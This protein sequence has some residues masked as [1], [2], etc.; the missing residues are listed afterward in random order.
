ME[1]VDIYDAQGPPP[2]AR[3]R[4]GKLPWPRGSTCWLWACGL[5]TGRVTS[6]SPSAA[7]RSAGPPASGRTPPATPRPG[8]TAPAA[9]AREIRR[10]LAWRLPRSSWS[11]WAAAQPP[12]TISARTTAC[13]C[14]SGRSALTFQP[15]ETCA[16]KWVTPEELDKMAQSGELSPSVLS[17]LEGSYR[18]AFL[19]FIGR[20][21]ST[22]LRKG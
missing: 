12:A 22:L 20:Q 15:G 2:P 21:G 10:R 19:Q 16:A 13:A 1:L 9:M 4:I 6:S 7:R 11:P 5:W 14:A 18:E 8:R 3:S 17:H